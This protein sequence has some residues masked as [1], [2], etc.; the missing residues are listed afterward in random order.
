MR[1][2]PTQSR[3]AVVDSVLCVAPTPPACS[4]IPGCLAAL[5]QVLSFVSEVGPIP[6]YS[7]RDLDY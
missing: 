7:A 2:R 3:D 1:Q 6:Y 5:V 4:G